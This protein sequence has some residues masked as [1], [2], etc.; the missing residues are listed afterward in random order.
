MSRI[1]LGQMVWL[2]QTLG[3]T[4]ETGLLTSQALDVICSKAP[5]RRMRLVLANVLARVNAGASLTNAFRAQGCFPALF[6]RFV[7][8]GEAT[9]SLDHTVA[10]LGRYYRFRQ[11]LY[12]R[13]LKCVMPFVVLYAVTVALLPTCVF[14]ENILHGRLVFPFGVL[15]RGYGLP[16][17]LLASY[18]LVLKP[19][20]G[21]RM[22][23][24]AAMFVPLLGRAL[25]AF[26]LARFS[27]ALNLMI[28]A[29][30]PMGEALPMSLSAT[31]NS[32]FTH[33]SRAAT[34][35]VRRGA[36]IKEALE[37]TNVFPWEYLEVIGIAEASGTVSE[38]LQRLASHHSERAEFYLDKF[39]TSMVIIIRLSVMIY[40][41]LLIF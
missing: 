34:D 24:R 40:M 25:K 7:E 32:I 3:A 18:H 19:M 20:G 38:Q 16:L 33:H 11:R 5:Y 39:A 6:L 28:E 26:A 30:V 29:T 12:R 8:V 13:F 1:S 27:M 14:I 2:C 10:E 9:G 15:V 22:V 21:G 23:H 17:A 36:A 31:N 4:L 41:V 37:R 35:A